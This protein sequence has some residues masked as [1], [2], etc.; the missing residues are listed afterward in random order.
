VIDDPGV[1]CV[2]RLRS[3]IPS[4]LTAAP[5]RCPSNVDGWRRDAVSGCP[6]LTKPE[7]AVKDVCDEKTATARPRWLGVTDGRLRRRK[8]LGRPPTA[9]HVLGIDVRAEGRGEDAQ[10]LRARQH[11]DEGQAAVHPGRVRRQTQHAGRERQ[12]A[13]RRVRADGHVLP[14]GRAGQAGRPLSLSRQ[15]P[16]AER[17]PSGR[18]SLVRPGQ[19][20][21]GRDGQRDR[22]VVVQQVRDLRGRDRRPT[23]PGLRRVDVGPAGAERLQAHRRPE[24]KTPRRVRLQRQAGPAVRHFEQHHLRRGLVRLPAEQR[25]RLRRSDRHQVPARHA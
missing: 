19:A 18:V 3:A 14:A 5:F 4:S 12:R 21:R 25:R 23:G 9:V 16:A 13:R 8:L 24:R 20:A 17:L 11:G 6:R 1:P 22:A 10:G 2:R 7:R 15:V